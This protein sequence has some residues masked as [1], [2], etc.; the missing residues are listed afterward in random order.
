M[1]LPCSR[2]R[3]DPP[4]DPPI[5]RRR[6]KIS[7]R[8]RRRR[9]L[10]VRRSCH[11]AQMRILQRGAPEESSDKT[12]LTRLG[13]DTLG[14][15]RKQRLR[16]KTEPRGKVC[17]TAGRSPSPDPGPGCNRPESVSGA[18]LLPDPGGYVGRPGTARHGSSALSSIVTVHTA[19][20]CV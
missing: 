7:G 4:Y 18:A 6:R 11:S 19:S 17:D 2:W 14:R 12:N 20:C 10:P 3:C 13:N 9:R 8:R 15:K 1:S 5:N 16:G